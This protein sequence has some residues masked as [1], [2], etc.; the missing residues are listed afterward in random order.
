MKKIESYCQTT[1]DCFDDIHPRDVKPY[2]IPVA[3][4]VRTVRLDFDNG[5]LAEMQ[6][7]KKKRKKLQ[8]QQ[9]RQYQQDQEN[10][11]N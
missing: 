6:E 9:L 3:Q 4:A 5:K 10:E 7:L 2:L 1:I 8:R 11:S